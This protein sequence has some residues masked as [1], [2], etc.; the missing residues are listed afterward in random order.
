MVEKESTRLPH[1]EI[2]RS[3][4]AVLMS[5]MKRFMNVR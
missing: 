5:I 2:L 1:W 4:M 3:L